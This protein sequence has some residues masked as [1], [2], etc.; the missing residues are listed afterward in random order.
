MVQAIVSLHAMR[1]AA[2]NSRLYFA[3]RVRALCGLAS[4]SISPFFTHSVCQ[5]SRVA[6]GYP[7]IRTTLLLIV[8]SR[9]ASRYLAATGEIFLALSRSD[10]CHVQA[11]LTRA[12][13]TSAK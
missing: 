4:A 5:A 1:L 10:D 7:F 2:I 11:L 3:N 12:I 8:T 6:V 9:R 13:W